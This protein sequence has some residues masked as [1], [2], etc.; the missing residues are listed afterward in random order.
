MATKL[1]QLKEQVKILEQQERVNNALLQ[2]RLVV[3]FTREDR[4][5]YT[6][7]SSEYF[8]QFIEVTS[9]T[10]VIRGEDGAIGKGI[11]PVKRNIPITDPIKVKSISALEDTFSTLLGADKVSK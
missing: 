7:P 2:G 9:D 8:V 5:R 3:Q 10:D 4:D 6:D 1:E 11:R